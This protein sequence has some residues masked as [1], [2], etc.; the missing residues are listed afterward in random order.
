MPQNIVYISI[1]LYL[2]GFYNSLNN[3]LAGGQISFSVVDGEPYVKVGA[4]APRPFSGKV[5][6]VLDR[7]MSTNSIVEIGTIF[8][9]ESYCTAYNYTSTEDSTGF[10]KKVTFNKR[11][12][13]TLLHTLA[14]GT[15][16]TNVTIKL[17]DTEI[18]TDSLTT[19]TSSHKK[20]EFTAEAGDILDIQYGASNY[21]YVG[22]HIVLLA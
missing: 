21:A 6:A 8:N 11:C 14:N 4:D 9:D 7:N 15:N 2:R 12:R 20:T 10:H 13:V 17:N 5:I 1:L 18:F 19:K 3:S 16:R 22:G